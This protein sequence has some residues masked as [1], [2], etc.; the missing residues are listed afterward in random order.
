MHAITG[1]LG[2]L[3]LRAAA[4]LVEHGAARVLLASRGGSVVRDEQQCVAT[5]LLRSLA[6][7]TETLACDGSETYDTSALLCGS[8]A[9]GVFHAAG[10]GDKGLAV[11]LMAHK[12]R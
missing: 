12:V 3:G 8:C 2:G 10:A 1:G 9:A 7:V 5:Q 6:A 4:L 11:E